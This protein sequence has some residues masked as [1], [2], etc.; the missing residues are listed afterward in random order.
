MRIPSALL[1]GF[2]ASL[3]GKAGTTVDAYQRELR[4]FLDW[5]SQRAGNRGPFNAQQHLTK[6]A[7]QTY[8]THLQSQGHSV[9]HCARVKSAMSGFARWLIEEKQLGILLTLGWW[10][11]LH[12]LNLAGFPLLVLPAYLLVK[13]V[14]NAAATVAKIAIAIFVPIYTAFDALAGIG[15][16]TLVLW[17]SQCSSPV[18]R[19]CQGH[20]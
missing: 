2:I 18:N 12:V 11:T 7:L 5:I 9:S 17:D 10:I 19:E 3:S 13:D 20:S 4:H 8:L 1:K 14:N 16:G 6:T 15:T